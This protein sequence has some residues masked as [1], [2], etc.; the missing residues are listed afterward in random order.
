MK[1]Y[2][3]YSLTKIR[4]EKAIFTQNE[5]LSKSRLPRQQVLVEKKIIYFFLKPTSAVTIKTADEGIQ[6][7]PLCK[8]MYFP[9]L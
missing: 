4:G 8:N 6:T 1:L 5:S 7:G 3:N 9:A 2:V